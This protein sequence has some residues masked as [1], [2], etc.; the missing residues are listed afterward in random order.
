MTLPAVL[1]DETPAEARRSEALLTGDD[2][3]ELQE[4]L[5]WYGH[6]AGA[7]DGAFGP[8]TRRSMAEWQT[9][10]GLSRPAS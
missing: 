10:E 9:A 4:A 5:Q 2:R 3:K 6:Y 8:G 1:P 7:I